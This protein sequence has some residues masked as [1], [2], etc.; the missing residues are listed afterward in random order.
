MFQVTLTCLRPMALAVVMFIVASGFAPNAFA[1]PV[2]GQLTP[3]KL[4]LG[5]ETAP[6]G[7][8]GSEPVNPHFSVR[9]ITLS[10]GTQLGEAIVNGPAEPPPGYELAR[11]PVAPSELNRPGASSTLTVPA[12]NWV[13]GCGAVAASMIGAYYDRNGFPNIYTGPA[14]G[15]VMPLRNDIWPTW[16]D[17]VGKTYPSNPLAASRLGLDGRTTRGSIDDYWVAYES[18]AP[19][20]Y[21]TGGWAQHAWGDSFGDFMKTSQSAYGNADGET[22]FYWNTNGTRLTC[23][24]MSAES[25]SRDATFGRKLFYEARG[26]TVTDC[27]NQRTDNVVAGGFSFAE[28]K[29]QIDAGRPVFIM[30]EGHFVVGVS[31]NDSTTPGTVF[32]N[33]TWDYATH[34]MSWGGSYSGMRMLA[35]GIANL[36]S[37]VNP[38]PVI[39]GLNPAW[40]APGGPT[41]TLTVN[42]AGFVNGAVVRWNGANRTTNFINSSRL[43]ATITAA[44][45]VTAGTANVTVFNPTP[46]GGTSSARSFLIGTPKKTRL[47]V[48]LRNF[49]PLPAKP[50]LSPVSND[51]GD[52]NYTVTWTS[53]TGAASYNLQED[54][55][56]SFT[57]PATVY[58]GGATFWSASGKPVGTYFYRVEAVNSWGAGGWSN[59]QWAIVQPPPPTGPTPGYWRHPNGNM[60]FYVTAD[61]G[62]VDR[63]AINVN[64]ENCGRYKITHVSPLEP[65]SGDSFSFWGSFYAFGTFGS[66]TAAS[67]MTGLDDYYIHGCGYITGGP[68]EWTAN[69]VHAVAQQTPNSEAHEVNRVEPKDPG[70]AFQASDVQ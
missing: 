61:R 17:G 35:V 9:T 16:T 11:A 37:S 50:T 62:Y 3:D 48:I 42:G 63:F 55:N 65:I 26:Y 31:Y 67:G 34:S 24:A 60:E 45:I 1:A 4:P 40:T 39:T 14:N 36:A 46:G 51:D 49:P 57:S 44:D 2:K 33:D 20:P 47:P 69:W 21:I 8:A 29:A 22:Y 19:D 13:F 53:A 64:V 58:S 18:T 54:D 5:A 23:A 38:I 66:S 52:G 10:D 56:S 12:Y 59:T 70:P 27:F 25:T 6:T 15:G 28:Y 32:L 30:L 7:T 68:W 41:L 43:T